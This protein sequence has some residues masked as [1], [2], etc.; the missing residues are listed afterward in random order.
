MAL[1]LL[2]IKI[3][4]RH[5]AAAV[6]SGKTLDYI[7]TLHLCNEPEAVTDTVARF[8]ARILEN[9]KPESAAIGI[10]RTNQGERVNALLAMTEKMLQASGIPVW[11][12]DDKT[13]LESYAI[14]KL[15]NK[16]Q[17]RPIVLSFW[18]HIGA[19]QQSGFEAVALGFHV[20]V[21]RLLSHH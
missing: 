17:L 11:K 18:P 9:L 1:K 2:A 10:S 15:K 14:P 21:E 7:D 13:L 20:Q 19:R 4:R 3:H 6:F 16:K 8:L 5:V 12:I